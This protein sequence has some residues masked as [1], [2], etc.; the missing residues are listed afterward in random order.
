MPYDPI[1]AM[2]TKKL[3]ID[4]LIR[5]VSLKDAILDLVDNAIDGFI[6]KKFDENREIKLTLNKDFFEIFD[7]CGGIEINHVKNEVFRFGISEV[8]DENTLGVYGIGMKR[9]MFKIGR[10]ITFESDD[11]SNYFRVVIDLE[12]WQTSEAW[13]HNF[14]TV[15]GSKGEPFTKISIESLNDD[16]KNEFEKDSFKNELSQRISKTYF[17][18]LKD[19]IN[20]FINNKYIEP[21][22]LKIGFS[23]SISPAVQNFSIDGVSVK[24]TAGAHPDFRDP[25]WYI[26]CNNRLIIVGD[27]T[28]LTGWGSRGVPTYHPKYNRFKGF[29]Y[30][31]SSDP[32][33][34][35][36][37]TSKNGLN[38]SSI[39]YKR[40][41][42][43]M[44]SMT[45][46]FTSYMSKVYPS[47]KEETI[48][49]DI[50]GDMTTVSITELKENRTF[51]APEIPRS[52]NFTTISYKKPKKQVDKLKSCLGN[53]WLS[54]K[55]VGE[56]T[57]D[58]YLE[59]ECEDDE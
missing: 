23:D 56:R 31:N 40:L 2:P 38:T 6:R 17:L 26:F 22:E 39:V 18:F 29:A 47:E 37:N 16:I 21:L 36:W 20:I 4:T 55:K 33:K 53:R 7:N 10:H 24:L 41:L 34:L 57:F 50:L 3:F 27:R 49:K 25:G 15:E 35:P 9:S 48:G 44:Q 46:Q 12:E 52:P 43:E 28:S 13:S 14:D 51:K 11:L 1:D 8:R 59:M 30:I 5:D 32:S 58:Y 42:D 19:K 45:Q 54:N